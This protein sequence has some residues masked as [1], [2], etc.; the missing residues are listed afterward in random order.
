MMNEGTVIED[1]YFITFLI[2]NGLP[3][4]RIGISVKKKFGYAVRRNRLKRL[5]KEVYR[6]KKM[7][8]PSGYDILFIAR[9]E[10]SDSFKRSNIGYTDIE[11]VILNITVNKMKRVNEYER[12][13]TESDNFL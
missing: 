8:F 6:T 5:V 9:K 13:I 11:K 2:C 3:F 7:F 1:R 12:T 4:S 10:L